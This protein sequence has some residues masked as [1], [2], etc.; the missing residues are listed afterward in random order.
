MTYLLPATGRYF[1]F[2][3]MNVI[4]P[5][6]KPD[7]WKKSPQA[8]LGLLGETREGKVSGTNGTDITLCDLFTIG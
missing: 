8:V 6:R 7:Q 2:S 5:R 1:D 4:I 3:N